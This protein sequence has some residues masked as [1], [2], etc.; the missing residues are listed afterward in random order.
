MAQKDPKIKEWMEKHPDVVDGIKKRYAEL[1]AYGLVRLAEMLEG[2][3]I[4]VDGVKRTMIVAIIK[5]ERGG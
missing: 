3:D 1:S 2:A 4:N 5:D